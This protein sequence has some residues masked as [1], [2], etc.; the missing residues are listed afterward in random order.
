MITNQIFSLKMKR[1]FLLK[2]LA[3]LILIA[4]LFSCQDHS[5]GT[6]AKRF[7]L[8]KTVL[9]S[10][11]S[12]VPTATIYNYDNAGKLVN[13]NFSS[14]LEKDVLTTLLYDSQSRVIGM[15]VTKMG[16]TTGRATYTYDNN[17]NV[18]SVIKLI[19]DPKQAAGN[20][21]ISVTF[22]FEYGPDKLPTKAYSMQNGVANGT[23]LYTYAG[24]NVVKL[25]YSLPGGLT[26]SDTFTFDNS[27]NPYQGK[28]NFSQGLYDLIDAINK[29]NYNPVPQLYSL[30]YNSDG[31]LSKRTILGPIST[32]TTYEYE[33]F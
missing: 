32:Q 30:E 21:A 7:R 26:K 23:Y 4:T 16:A 9:S 6:G 13:Y 18:G 31:L 27:P 17:G 33:E 1:T 11:I 24:G 29:N 22:S 10:A 5:L 19:D 2:N 8:K 3:C 15:E 25:D 20:L 28:M 14:V 12:S